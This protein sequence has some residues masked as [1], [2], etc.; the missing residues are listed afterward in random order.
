MCTSTVRAATNTWSP[1]TWS[2]SWALEYI[3]FFKQKTAYE[4]RTDW[5]SDVCSSDLGGPSPI[6]KFRERFAWPAPAYGCREPVGALTICGWLETTAL[7]ATDLPSTG[8]NLALLAAGSWS[9]R[10]SVV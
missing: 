5:S 9:D 10:K 2:R 8:W 1:Q 7:M 6:L 4:M 3:F